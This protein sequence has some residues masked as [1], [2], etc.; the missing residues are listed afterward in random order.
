ESGCA[1]KDGYNRPS[2]VL[3][4]SDHCIAAHPSDM[5]V[6][7]AILD[8]TVRVQG[9]GGDRAIPFADFHLL[10]GDTPERETVLDHGELI[11][12]VELPPAPWAA[13]SHSLKVRA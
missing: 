4:V 9:P 3:G 12:A 7:L 1:A 6:A 5:C 10:P 8:A 13:R 2:A 11:T